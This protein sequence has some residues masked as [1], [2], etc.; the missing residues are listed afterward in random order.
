MVRHFPTASPVST[1]L[2]YTPYSLTVTMMARITLHLKRF[3]HSNTVVEFGDTRWDETRP[4]LPSA[5]RPRAALPRARRTSRVEPPPR[6]VYPFGWATSVP[7]QTDTVRMGGESL[8][9]EPFSAAAPPPPRPSSG[10]GRPVADRPAWPV[11]ID[12]EVL[13]S[14]SS[15]GDAELAGGRGHA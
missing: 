4:R 5:S 10:L 9:L 14:P 2:I 6:V 1:V 11:H 8:A 7:A 3:A 12:L 15:V 13:H